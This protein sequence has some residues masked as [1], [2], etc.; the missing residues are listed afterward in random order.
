MKRL[1]AILPLTGL[2][3]AGFIVSVPARAQQAPDDDRPGRGVARLSLINGDVSIKRGDSGDWVAGV[4]NAPL[5]AEDRI[6]TGPMARTEVQ[7]DFYHRL[8]IAPDSDVRLAELEYRR[9]MMQLA[10]GAVTFAALPGGDAQVEISTPGAAVRPVA[11]GSYRVTVLPD[12]T[13]E[14][15]VRRG[16]AEIFT[17]RGSQRLRP[18]KTMLVRPDATDGPE[19]QLVSAIGRDAWDQFNEARDRELRRGEEIYSRY[20]PRDIY[21]AEDLAGHG[22]WV[23]VAPYGH[24]WQPFVAAGW[25]PYTLGR[26]TWLDWYGWSWVSYDPW[27][28]APYHYGRW[29]MHAGHWCWYPGAFGARHWW[30]PA[31]VGWIGF[32]GANWGVGLGFGR[33]GWV[34]LAPYDPLYPWWGHGIYG[35]FRGRNFVQNNITIVNNTNVTN[36]YRNAR[37]NNAVTVMNGD[38]FSRGN[39]GR[40]SRAAAGDLRNAH[41]VRGAVP[42]APD[43]GALRYSNRD[44][45]AHTRIAPGGEERFYSRRE[46]PRVD[47]VPFEEQRRAFT[48]AGDGSRSGYITRANAGDR[49]GGTPAREATSGWR[50]FGEPRATAP[51]SETANPGSRSA[52]AASGFSRSAESPRTE[53]AA[54]LRSGWRRFGDPGQSGRI[55]TARPEASESRGWS[56]LGDRER[57]SAP[58]ASRAGSE[59]RNT[60]STGGRSERMGAPESTRTETPRAG[61]SERSTWST[62]GGE[63][64][65]APNIRTETPR[66]GASERNTWSTSGARDRSAPTAPRTEAPATAPSG[67]GTWSTGG[68]RERMSAPNQDGGG[69]RQRSV[70]PSAPRSESP[71]P[72]A[73]ERTSWSTGGSFNATPRAAT[74]DGGRSTWSTGGAR[75]ESRS[76]G[77]SAPRAAS[78]DG[79]RSSWSTGGARGESR[80]GGFSAPRAASPDGGRSSWSTGGARGESRSGGFSAPRAASPDGGRSSWSTSAPRS[81]P[82]MQMPSSSGGG[83]SRSGGF[84]SGGMTT[85]SRSAPSFGG[86][87]RSGPSPSGRGSVLA[88][89][90]GGMRSSGG[91]GS[92][93]GGRGGR[94]E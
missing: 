5:L 44:S 52:A 53:G 9:Y 75:G 64:M 49:G 43:R 6:A 18:G 83:F 30:R 39:F 93:M 73:N 42:V 46:V 14:I 47:R 10:R 19:F 4:I 67:R 59:G 87:V 22:R 77:F 33:I 38:D 69:G 25:A 89:G 86:G 66:S 31:L 28:W 58:D 56:T 12:G 2:L 54:E 76:G 80:S 48:S 55:E 79:G 23:Y 41:L 3:L 63:R 51:G 65:N 13:A 92:R 37:F 57:I 17:P 40:Y 20:V 82:R 88:P 26:W 7:F 11:H 68:S 62:G 84:G 94:Q 45:R 85:P 70:A 71:R 27:G 61:G 91:G 32:G 50:R 81:E 15:T 78:P 21:G 35:G 60:W 24:V 36:I 8:R 74:P 34:P 90:G 72:G 29:F 16:E 1:T